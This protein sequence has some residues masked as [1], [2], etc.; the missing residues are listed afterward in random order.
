[1]RRLRRHRA[2]DLRLTGDLG[3]LIRPHRRASEPRSRS[4]FRPKNFPENT[5]LI[6]GTLGELSL[7]HQTH[8]FYV[9]GVSIEAAVLPDGWDRADRRGARCLGTKGH[10]GHCL[11]AHDLAASKLVAG[12]EKD[13]M[14]VATLLRDGLVDSEIL[15]ERVAEL[16]VDAERGTR[17][18]S[19]SASRSRMPAA[20]GR[21]SLR[22]SACVTRPGNLCL[23]LC[24]GNN[25]NTGFC[26]AIVLAAVIAG[27]MSEFSRHRHQRVAGRIDSTLDQ[28]RA[29]GDVRHFLLVPKGV[30][31]DFVRVQIA[32]VFSLNTDSSTLTPVDSRAR[33]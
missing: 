21:Q 7:F 25:A 17:S 13:R 4:T 33:M 22:S 24:A 3:E 14:F 23:P 15:L 31:L 16:P 5:D 6:D 28:A 29:H 30:D 32:D 2:P 26:G 9:H 10:T 18:R 20:D 27:A 12:R 1:M 19:G 8:G 11:E